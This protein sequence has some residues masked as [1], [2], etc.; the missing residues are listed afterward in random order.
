MTSI[1]FRYFFRENKFKNQIGPEPLKICSLISRISRQTK[2]LIDP[3]L[4]FGH[5]LQRNQLGVICE[6]LIL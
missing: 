2:T 4:N 1:R 3:I 5:E 6:T